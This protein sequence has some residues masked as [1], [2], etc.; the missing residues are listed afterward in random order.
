MLNDPVPSKSNLPIPLTV[1][2]GLLMGAADSVPGVSGGTIALIVGVYERLIDSLATFLR[3]PSLVRSAE[4][5]TQLRRALRF[6]V[7]LGVGVLAAYY[8]GTLLL[9]GPTESK[10]WLRRAD[11]APLC[12]AFFFGLV[13]FSLFEPWRRIP[14]PGAVAYITA[15][16]F[17]VAVAWMV[18][19]EHATQA[20]EDWMLLYG[21]AFAVA[22]MLLPGISGSLLLLVLGQYTTVAG[23]VHDR[24]FGK[25]TIFLLG[26]AIGVAAFVPV[27]RY[28][29]RRHHD[30]T[31]AALTGLMA[32]SLRA[33]WPWKSHYD[34]KDVAR[35]RM[36]NVG[37]E[38]NWPWI[39]L[40]L[41]AG[42]A[43]V[44]LLDRLAR[45][46]ASSRA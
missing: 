23:A 1:G 31:L 22:V 13:L 19:L 38:S 27:L 12:Y 42:A 26:V 35:G 10:G 39:L 3:L 45:K 9:V 37:M 25:L 30:L 29:L 34:L 16:A 40:A 46:M 32:G 36:V 5:R 18:G 11:T 17:A 44:W 21:G 15:A 20:P 33:L 2:A 8:I 28:L 41:A 6:L 14:K 4:G 24:D 7:P 43:S